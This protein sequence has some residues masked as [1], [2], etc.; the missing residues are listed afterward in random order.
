MV[1]LIMI[2]GMI[3][4]AALPGSGSVQKAQPLLVEIA[5]EDPQ[6]VISVIVQMLGEGA[7]L[8]AKVVRLGGEITKELQIINA[9]AAKMSAGAVLELAREPEVRWIS[10]DAPM[11][12]SDFSANTVADYFNMPTYDN[13]DGTASWKGGWQEFDV[14]GAGPTSGNVSI[15]GDMLWLNDNPNTNTQPSIARSV[16]LSGNVGMANLSFDLYAYHGVDYGSDIAVVEISPDGGQTFTELEV[17][18]YLTGGYRGHYSYDILSYASS[19]TVVRFRIVQYFG[20]S[21]E[22]L[23]I[24]NLQIEYSQFIPAFP[25][26]Y[27]DTTGVNQ[28]HADGLTG[29]GV[30][31]AVIDSGIDDHPDF[32]GRLIHPEGF[33]SLDTYGHGTHVAGIIGGSGAGSNGAYTGVAP[34]VQL[35]D[36]NITDEFGMAYESDV[37]YA[38]QW[39]NDNKDIYNIRVVNMSLNSTMENS[40]HESPLS[41]ASEILWFNGVTVVASVGNKGPAGGPNTAKTAPAND[42]FLIVVGA[43]D[44]QDTQDR[45][46]DTI[47]SFSSFGVT[48]DGLLRPNLVAPG[49]NIVSSLS[50]HSSWDIEAPHRVDG[51]YIHLSGT[52][53]A[54]P[55]VAGVAALMLEQDPSLTP[56]QIKYRLL[57]FS[58][59]IANDEYSFPYL[60][61]YAAVYSSSTES[62]NIG[63]TANKMLWSGDDPVT[64][65]SV[66]WNSVAW[67]SVAWNSVAWNSVAWNSVAWNSAIE[68]DGIFWGPRS[69]GDRY[70]KGKNK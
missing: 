20:G 51:Q 67:N 65:G 63:E 45:S 66:A 3:A 69:K 5:A 17:Y 42:P 49:F 46:D 23:I 12:R 1:P 47:G 29:T 43:S 41:A 31:V 56:D 48:S 30:G 22:W 6:Q 13:Q 33:P 18:D 39:V 64:W 68:L 35:F 26:T 53:M 52:S 19:E 40:Y 14:A 37:V 24:D 11:E 38:L 25:Y 61:A 15:Y 50:S 57:N 27:H 36:L 59:A 2:F 54:A 4:M 44:E 8:E 32:F 9:F 16:D 58:N 70:G 60:D 10:L 7:G 55:L 28:L 62:A 34:G 21:N